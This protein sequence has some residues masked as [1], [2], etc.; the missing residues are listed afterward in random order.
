MWFSKGKKDCETVF[1]SVSGLL[2][3]SFLQIH[4]AAGFL[5]QLLC[6]RGC[7]QVCVCVRVCV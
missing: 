1:V 5:L 2:H 3:D 6:V 7:V 4:T